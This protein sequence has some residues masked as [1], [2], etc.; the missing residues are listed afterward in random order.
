MSTGVTTRLNFSGYVI[1]SQ[2]TAKTKTF[3]PDRTDGPN[4]FYLQRKP[5]VNPAD[6]WRGQSKK[7][8]I[9]ENIFQKIQQADSLQA[10]TKNQS[11]RRLKH[12]RQQHT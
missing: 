2:S 10:A 8:T 3:F 9:L 1:T 6:M 12:G 7:K 4:P 11:T 5:K